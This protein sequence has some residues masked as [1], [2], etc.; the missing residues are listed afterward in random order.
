MKLDR[1][2]FL[3]QTGAGAGALVVSAE[4][5]QPDMRRPKASST[6]PRI[7]I[8]L[9]YSAYL[10]K[11]EVYEFMEG[12]VDRW[13][14][15][16]VK[17][18]Y[19][20]WIDHKKLVDTVKVTKED[21]PKPLRLSWGERETWEVYEGL[22]PG[23][24]VGSFD[25]VV[26][27]DQQVEV[28]VLSVL[29]IENNTKATLQDKIKEAFNAYQYKEN[30]DSEDAIE[31]A[32]T[33]LATETE[34]KTGMFS[35]EITFSIVKVSGT[36]MTHPQQ[37]DAL[38]NLYK[39]EV[40]GTILTDPN[41]PPENLEVK[42]RSY[43]A[44]RHFRA[45]QLVKDPKP[46]EGVTAN[47]R[48]PVHG[49]EDDKKQSS[50]KIIEDI[51]KI[52]RE[53]MNCSLDLIKPPKEW[54]IMILAAWPEFKVEWRD[55]TYTIGCGVQFVLRLPVLQT[56]TTGLELWAYA[57]YASGQL[58]AIYQVVET[59]VFKSALAGGVIGIAMA[60]IEV[61]V[62]VFV[63]LLQQCLAVQVVLCLIP[64]LALITRV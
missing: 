56:R 40:R 45:K 27:K 61:A 42:D 52:E 54:P 35:V 36:R 53:A 6:G 23:I 34:I 57:Q 50:T 62:S 59:C 9:D 10:D 21:M 51:I 12:A 64:G 17:P 47:P 18:G 29:W 33:K 8:Q 1:R 16:L 60:N 46:V 44:K 31:Y 5:H 39:G 28:E 15:P 58:P 41:L 19:T 48:P 20:A 4:A 13:D 55:F 38:L 37:R 43:F 7:P 63:S 26:P 25:V 2:R 30:T 11:Q 24:M 14:A 32:R 49:A 22:P 3:K